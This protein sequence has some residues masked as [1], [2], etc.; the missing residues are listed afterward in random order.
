MAGKW[1]SKKEKLNILSECDQE[2]NSVNEIAE[3]YD[4]HAETIR[5]WRTSHDMAGVESLERSKCHKFYPAELKYAAVKDFL[6]G[7]YTQREVSR[8]YKIS[9]KSVLMKWV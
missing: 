2:N 7:R 3:K 6:S 1:F 4:I 9:S 5:E 8:K